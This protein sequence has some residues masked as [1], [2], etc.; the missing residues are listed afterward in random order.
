[1]F[2]L[3]DFCDTNTAYRPNGMNYNDK[4]DSDMLSNSPNKDSESGARGR[5]E[6]SSHRNGES[7]SRQLSES[8]YSR[9]LRTRRR[10]GSPV[11]QF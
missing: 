2:K 9:R 10:R 1:M 3:S 11:K 8:G 7:V 5:R 6:P 4:S